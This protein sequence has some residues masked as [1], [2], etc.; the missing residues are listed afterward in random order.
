[1]IKKFLK[2]SYVYFMLFGFYSGNYMYFRFIN[3]IKNDT[4]T[5]CR[6]IFGLTNHMLIKCC[7]WIKTNFIKNKINL[8]KQN[9]IVTSNHISYIDPI[10][11][12]SYF[13]S[14]I[15]NFE[16]IQLICY[17]E[18]LSW[19]IIGYILKSLGSIPIKFKNDTQYD[20]HSVQDMYKESISCLQNNGSILILPE[21][22]LNENPK[23]LNK[24]RGGAYWLSKL[25]GTPI[26]IIGMRGN[27]K[28]WSKIGNPV[29]S[30]I[31]D[32]ECL[33]DN[34]VFETIE[35]YK[36]KWHNRVETFVNK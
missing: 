3:L 8:K 25:T 29:G 28:I 12:T 13:F 6:K 5:H 9:L 21:G 20:Q 35:E 24:I 10:V 30:G 23:K 14:N 11:L 15:E 27:D 36:I 31:I 32:I 1:M 7:P 34:I 22:R 18:I 2:G 16:N 19:S 26:C 33:E 4:T 17:E